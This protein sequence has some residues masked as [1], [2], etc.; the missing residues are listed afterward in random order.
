MASNHLGSVKACATEVGSEGFDRRAVR[1][2]F[3]LKIPALDLVIIGWPEG[4]D[5][6][7][8]WGGWDEEDVLGSVVTGTWLL[9]EDIGETL[10]DEGDEIWWE[11]WGR[12]SWNSVAE[13]GTG[14]TCIEEDE[15][16]VSEFDRLEFV[17]KEKSTPDWY[18]NDFS[19]KITWFVTY[20]YASAR[21]ELKFM[22]I[23]GSKIGITCTSKNS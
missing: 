9:E 21:P 5:A 12:G 10:M 23:I 6:G 2:V 19:S 20:E 13:K 14:K 3:G 1:Y 18:G 17:T 15:D 4:C 22:S 7:N 16:V 8:W 11:P